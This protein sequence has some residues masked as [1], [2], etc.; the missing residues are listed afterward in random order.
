MVLLILYLLLLSILFPLIWS[1]IKSLP[2][3]FDIWSD[4]ASNLRIND[5]LIFGAVFIFPFWNL[6]YRW[7]K[8]Q[9][10]IE[11]L[12]GIMIAAITRES[13]G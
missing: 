10:D 12:K 9:G 3:S 5:L 11:Y 1:D 2:A 13:K 4:F 6:R 7:R 8:A